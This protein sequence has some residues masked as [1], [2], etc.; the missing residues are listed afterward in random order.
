MNVAA[1]R[2][3]TPR[4]ARKFGPRTKDGARRPDKREAA[5]AGIPQWLRRYQK[6]YGL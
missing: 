4:G 5:K 3:T 2:K 6:R 1:K